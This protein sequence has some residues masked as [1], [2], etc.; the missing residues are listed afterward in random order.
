MKVQTLTTS[1][2]LLM[3]L[4]GC[5]T[6]VTSPK[7]S[8]SSNAAS[9]ITAQSKLSTKQVEKQWMIE[10]GKAQKSRFDAYVT[11]FSNALHSCEKSYL[12]EDIS[13]RELAADKVLSTVFVITVSGPEYK[14]DVVFDSLK[15]GWPD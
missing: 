2:A 5:G 4:T 7:L 11:R 13:I 1:I 9:A 8:T 3:M 10:V 12:W 14:V 6:A 15:S